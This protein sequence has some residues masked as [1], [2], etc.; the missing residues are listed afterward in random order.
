MRQ[1]AGAIMRLA[2]GVTAL[3][4]TVAKGDLAIFLAVPA[5][6]FV[7]IGFTLFVGPINPK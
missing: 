1:I 6:I 4:A 5:F 3:A 7:V 2:A